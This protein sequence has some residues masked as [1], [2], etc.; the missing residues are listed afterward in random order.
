MV[1]PSMAVQNSRT[2]PPSLRHSF[3]YL[4]PGTV[5]TFTAAGD[6]VLHSDLASVLGGV[7]HRTLE[8]DVR[9]KQGLK[10]AA[11]LG[12]HK[13]VPAIHDGHVQAL[14]GRCFVG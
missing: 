7:E 14:L 2:A 8:H 13:I 10:A 11:V 9:M 6:E 5:S 1:M 4:N 12:F 3:V